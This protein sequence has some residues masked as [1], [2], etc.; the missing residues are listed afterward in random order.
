M[1]STNEVYKNINGIPAGAYIGQFNR[2]TELDNRILARSFPSA[3]LQPNYD[4]RP[5]S[6]KYS[7]MPA[8]SGRKPNAEPKKEYNEYNVHK[9]FNPCNDGAPVNGFLNNVDHETYLRNQ[10]FALQKGDK[11]HYVPKGSS[12]LF[13][14]Y[15]FN[16]VSGEEQPHPGLFK[17]EEFNNNRTNHSGLDGIGVDYF[18]NNT[19]T[20]LR[21]K[22]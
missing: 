2:T 9:T 11:Q 1:A 4:P 8:L 12:E 21:T 16:T 13:N 15:L 22:Y 14:D 3:P 6:T 7:L 17:K 19:R 18:H 10:Y 5:I 20:Q